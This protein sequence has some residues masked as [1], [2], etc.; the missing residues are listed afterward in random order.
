MPLDE[1]RT[2]GSNKKSSTLQKIDLQAISS[3]FS[4]LILQNC[5]VQKPNLEQN[6]EANDVEKFTQ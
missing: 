2:D 5:V 4:N 3:N 1:I 6:L